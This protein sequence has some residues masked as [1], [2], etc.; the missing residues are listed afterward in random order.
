MSHQANALADLQSKLNTETH[1]SDWYTVTQE[2]I[3]L[4]AEATGDHQWIHTDPERAKAQSPFGTTIAHGYMT[5]SLIVMLTDSVDP[6][7]PPYEGVVMGINYGCNRVR[8]PNPVA[9]NSKIRSRTTLINVEEKGNA[10]QIVNKVT[11]E[12]EG[13]QKPGCVAETVSRLYFSN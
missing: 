7:N 12:I 13:V 11:I 3:N 2:N 9:V 4:F 10:L 6:E 5:L 1:V 8:F